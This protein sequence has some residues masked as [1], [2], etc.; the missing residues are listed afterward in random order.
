MAFSFSESNT[1]ITFILGI[2]GI[3][4]LIS[5]VFRW[6]I[7]KIKKSIEFKTGTSQGLQHLEERIDEL[8]N[9]IQQTQNKMDQAVI[10][11]KE[12][13]AEIQMQYQG[14][15]KDL[16]KLMGQMSTLLSDYDRK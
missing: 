7:N 14:L 12:E 5:T 10:K 4:G 3:I 8:C 1:I 6:Q 16:Y 15:L 9:Q 13:H 2:G 11:S